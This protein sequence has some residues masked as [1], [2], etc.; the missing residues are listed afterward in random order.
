MSPPSLDISYWQWVAYA[1]LGMNYGEFISENSPSTQMDNI[2]TA[3]ARGVSDILI[4]PVSPAAR[5]RCCV[6]SRGGM[7]RSPSPASGRSQAVGLHIVCHRRQL[8]NRQGGRDL[9]LQPRQSARK[10]QGGMLS[11]PQ[12]HETAQKY[13]KGAKES[14]AAAATSCNSCRRMA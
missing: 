8:R 14:F 3:L 7:C 12:D 6:C 2:D 1:K 10:Q 13:L 9:R 11:L 5:R 4:G